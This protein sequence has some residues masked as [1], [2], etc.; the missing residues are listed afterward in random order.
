MNELVLLVVFLCVLVEDVV[1]F[2]SD[3]V[4]PHLDDV[5]WGPNELK[6]HNDT[7]IRPFRIHFHHD[8]I[9]DLRYRLLNHRPFTPPLE[10]VG[11]DYGFNTDYLHSWVDYWAN[12][13][14]F[15]EREHHLNQFPQFLTNIQGLDIHFLWVKPRVPPHVKVVPLLFLHGFPGSVV[16]LFKAIRLL[17]TYSE[18][19][20]FAIEVI[21][22]SLPGYA[23]SDAAIRPGLGAS[24]MGV[25][26]KNLMHRLGFDKFYIQGGDW[27][28]YIGMSMATIYPKE[29]LGYHTN[30]ATA[31]TLSAFGQYLIGA[32]HPPLVMSTAVMDRVYPITKY[33]VWLMTELGYMHI[34]SNKPDTVGVAMADSP[35]GLLAYIFQLFSS[36]SRRKYVY[37]ADGGLDDLYTR[38]ELLD[39]LMM[40]WVTNSFTTACRIYAET[41]NIRNLY[42]GIMGHPTP[43][44][45]WAIWAKDEITYLSNSMLKT[46]YTNLIHSTVLQGQ[47]HFLAFEAPDILVKDVFKAID[48]FRKWHKKH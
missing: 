42:L 28:S 22:P 26:F 18:D 45:T 35:A 16:E 34:Q 8:M 38:D 33:F 36:A 5:W 15:R 32:I 6:M 13:Y 3:P 21:A 25:V 47:G 9:Q 17:T 24:E 44:P 19:R 40:Y 48:A 20:D 27:G 39:N 23:F 1:M 37:R 31:I 7:S 30:L 43:V 46:K 14:N 29:I 12:H 2:K 11:F 4:L 10:G 41:E